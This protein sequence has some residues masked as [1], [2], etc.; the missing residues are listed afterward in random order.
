MERANNMNNQSDI[1]S[2]AFS[3]YASLS[4]V[5]TIV[6]ATFAAIHHTYEIGVH[7]VFLAVIFMALPALLMRWFKKTEKKS[8]LWIYGLLNTWLVVGF[9]LVDGLWNH[10]LSPLGLNLHA[11]MS[12]HGGGSPT[13]DKAIEGNF[14]YD[15][16]GV[17]TFIASMFA[18]YYAYKFIQTVRQAETTGEQNN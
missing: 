9:G 4:L 10:I 15:A 16:T 13:V 6:T 5:S 14:I 17:L 2:K 8:P 11:L 1:P 12:L 7:A 3:K 18:A